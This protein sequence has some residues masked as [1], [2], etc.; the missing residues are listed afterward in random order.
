VLDDNEIG[1]A[2]DRTIERPENSTLIAGT[3]FLVIANSD[4]GGKREYKINIPKWDEW[5]IATSLALGTN[6]SRVITF[7]SKVQESNLSRGKP[8]GL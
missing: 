3:H 5:T 6:Q 1:G 8:R 7:K 2:I 4:A